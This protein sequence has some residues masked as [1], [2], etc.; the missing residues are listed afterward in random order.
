[1]GRIGGAEPRFG[2][3]GSVKIKQTLAYCNSLI[4]SNERQTRPD[5]RTVLSL[6]EISLLVCLLRVKNEGDSYSRK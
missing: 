1:M 6:D 2:I 5:L 3:L 4:I